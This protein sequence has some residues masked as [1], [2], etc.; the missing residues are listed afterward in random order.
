MF[1]CVY[2][3]YFIPYKIIFASSIL[4]Y[5]LA[6]RLYD[7]KRRITHSMT[8][9][10]SRV[11]TS[12]APLRRFCFGKLEHNLWCGSVHFN[13]S[14][15]LRSPCMRVTLAYI[16]VLYVKCDKRKGSILCTE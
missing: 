16:R 12:K 11:G 9:C 13:L 6:S 10:W 14:I 7:R 1:Q 4:Y 15:E 2:N 8:A 5:F 3:V